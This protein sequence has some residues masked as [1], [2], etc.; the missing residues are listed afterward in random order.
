MEML[1]TM[2]SALAAPEPT[3]P[4]FR[5][6]WTHYWENLT[7]T[8]SDEPPD[9]AGDLSTK[10]L[11]D[12]LRLQGLAAYEKAMSR[13]LLRMLAD[14]EA[15]RR[16]TEITPETMRA[17]SARIRT[18]LSLFS[19]NQLMSWI[20][21]NDL[22]DRSF[23]RLVK[24]QA[25]LR[26]LAESSGRFLDRFI[27]DELRS[28]GA[29]EGLASRARRKAESMGDLHT[30]SPGSRPASAPDPLQLRLW[31]FEER[32]GESI[33]ED[34]EA[35]A[36]ALGFSDATEFDRVLLREWLYCR[37]E[38]VGHP[39]GSEGTQGGSGA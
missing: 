36:S 26:S 21:Q 13:A 38:G 9:F 14:R 22:D 34:I 12:E 2:Q 4:R 27:L 18:A 8:L 24:E 23:E 1:S 11:L 31:L 3:Q 25:Q 15:R 6:E 35:L 37:R 39:A 32:L 5:F 33:P 20:A 28:S 7:T 10:S 17:T 19:R 16:G 29:Y 30:G